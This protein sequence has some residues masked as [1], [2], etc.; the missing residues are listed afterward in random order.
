MDNGIN[1][2]DKTSYIVFSCNKCSQ[3]IYVRSSQKF[4]KCV[5]CGYI[6]KL[7]KRIDHG[8]IIKGISNAVDLI[9]KKQNDLA[10]NELGSEPEFRTLDDF[11]IT[12]KVKLQKNNAKFNNE[13]SEYFEKF[14]IMVCDL[15]KTHNSFPYYAIEIMAENY[16]IP[17]SEVKLLTKR[18]LRKGF[19]VR[20]K[21]NY[22]YK[23]KM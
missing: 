21:D 4:K 15:S 13:V 20:L 10:I 9:K 14:K 17:K 3:Y 22:L 16:G 12:Q 11:T 1:I 7:E 5:R 6:H 8:E 19:L 2:K 18:L 23:I